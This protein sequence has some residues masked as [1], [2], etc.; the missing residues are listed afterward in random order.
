MCRFPIIFMSVEV[1]AFS[2]KFLGKI[3]RNSVLNF[4]VL[5]WLV[6]RRYECIVIYF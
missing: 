4:L 3:F 1:F 2:V 5:C 6:V